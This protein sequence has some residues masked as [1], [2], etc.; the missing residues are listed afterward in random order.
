LIDVQ[1][2]TLGDVHHQVKSPIITAYQTAKLVIENPLLPPL[3]RPDIERLRSLSSKVVRVVRNMGMFSDLASGKPIR[4]K[5]E[6]LVNHKLLRMLREACEDHQILMDPERQIQ[7]NLEEKTFLDLSG[8]DLMRKL[9]EADWHCLNNA[10]IILWT[11]PRST[12][13]TEALCVWVPASRRGEAS[14]LSLLQTRVL[15]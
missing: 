8:Q 1:A 10:S 11:M 12:V 13:M 14:I 3:F 15:K 6:V 7:F 9:V 2:K 4:L 5:K